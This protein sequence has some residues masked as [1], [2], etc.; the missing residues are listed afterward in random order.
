MIQEDNELG[1]LLMSLENKEE[2]GEIFLNEEKVN[3]ELK[4]KGEKLSQS[5]LWYLDTGAINHMTGDRG[6]FHNLYMEIQGYVKGMSS[7]GMKLK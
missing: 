7:L 4:K 3:P 5:K 6:K 2:V 1:L